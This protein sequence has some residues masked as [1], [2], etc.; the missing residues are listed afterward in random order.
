MRLTRGLLGAA[1]IVLVLIGAYHL[2]GTSFPDGV[3]IVLWLAGGVL[4]HD[5]VIAPL[6]VL[7]A[8][9]VLPRLPSWSRAPVVAGFVVLG[10]ASLLAIPAIGRFGARVDVPSLLN[11]PYG[12]L[13]VL[14][15]AL[16]LLVVLAGSLLR[17]HRHTPEG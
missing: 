6:V 1:G 8:V 5:A 13:W 3:N 14:F 11:R 9:A 12:A 10:S 4:A 17:R 16:V 2:V 7:L 15:A